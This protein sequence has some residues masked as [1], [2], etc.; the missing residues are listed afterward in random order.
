MVVVM[1]AVSLWPLVRTIWLSFT[2]T[3]MPNSDMPVA[4]VGLV[5][6]V[7]IWEND[8][9][10]EILFR[11][12]YFS[13]SSVALQVL[14]GVSAALLLNESFRGRAFARALL[15]LPWALPTI[16][17]AMLWRLIT[18]PEYGSLNALLT[19]L[20]FME[21]YRSWLG[22]PDMAMNMVII[23]D[24]W[25]NFPVIAIFVLAALQSIPKDL[26]EAARLDGA[27]AFSRF[28]YITL[29]GI[30]PAL[31][32]AVMLRFIEAFKVFDIIYVMTRGGPADSTKTLS[33]LV[34]QETFSYLRSGSG[35][36]Y[37]VTVAL[38]CMAV[39]SVYIVNLK[40]KG[41]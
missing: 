32:I 37:A 2:D 9:F 11:T 33:F 25:K 17:N 40:R 30:A 4:W 16:V 24:S 20:G 5:N 6:Y 38:L 27:G 29:R 13:L 21:E 41:Q 26:Y 18:N 31:G 10:L 35:A 8:E 1:G 7:D 36:A 12:L 34:Y 15:V 22:D 28:R 19:Q 23:A 39:I 14:M 3:G